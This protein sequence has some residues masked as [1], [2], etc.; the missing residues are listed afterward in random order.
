M[1]GS[2]SE[3]V[4]LPYELAYGE[5][6]EDMPRRV[7]DISKVGRLIGYRPTVGLEEILRRVIAYHSQAALTARPAAVE[8]LAGPAVVP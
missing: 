8:A 5:G 4:T 6:F 7:P 3:I 2:R 1:T